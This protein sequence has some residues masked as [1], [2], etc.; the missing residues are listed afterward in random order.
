MNRNKHCPDCPDMPKRCEKGAL[1]LNTVHNELSSGFASAAEVMSTADGGGD[2][3]T[4]ARKG[5]SKRHELTMGNC[6]R[7]GGKGEGRNG[8]PP[9]M[10]WW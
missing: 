10:I 3:S 9:H 6:E 7:D 8:K 4:A 2:M 5:M 1:L